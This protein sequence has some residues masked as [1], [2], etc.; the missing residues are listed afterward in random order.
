MIVC[1]VTGIEA[2]G[3]RIVEN[4]RRTIDQRASDRNAAAHAAGKL[5]GKFVDG[6]LHLDETQRFADARLDFVFGDVF[7]AKAE[8]DVVVHIERIEERAFLK[9]EADAAAENREARTSFIWPRSWPMTE[10]C[11]ESGR[12]R[13]AASLRM[14]VFPEPLSPRSMFGLASCDFE[15]NAAENLVVLEIRG[16]RLSKT[17]SGS[18]GVGSGIQ[19]PVLICDRASTERG[20]GATVM[21]ISRNGRMWARPRRTQE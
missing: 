16:A 15:G 4:D 11:P 7:F 18:P 8:G 2:G 21:I 3:G 14:R 20:S 10:M 13:P 9:N 1:E 19:S 6:L 12:S 5:G 17:T